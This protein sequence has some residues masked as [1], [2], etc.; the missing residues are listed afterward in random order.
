MIRFL[1]I[2]INVTVAAIV[3][4]IT[5]SV[6]LIAW[7]LGAV[8]HAQLPDSVLVMDEAAPQKVKAVRKTSSVSARASTVN[9]Y[10]VRQAQAG[11][12]AGRQPL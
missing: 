3:F 7:F 2:G 12:K 8:I 1:K 4:V 5:T 9:T 10:P 6:G 11:N